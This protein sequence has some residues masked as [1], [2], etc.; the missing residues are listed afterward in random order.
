MDGFPKSAIHV[1][2]F[3][4]RIGCRFAFGFG[5]GRRLDSE[6]EGGDEKDVED[7]HVAIVD[8]GNAPV[9]FCFVHWLN[10]RLEL[11]LGLGLALA[12]T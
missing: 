12:L 3:E 4:D 2:G 7:L 1:A 5:D 11:V 10:G 8:A 6:G 9:S